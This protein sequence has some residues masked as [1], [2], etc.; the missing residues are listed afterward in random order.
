MAKQRL[1]ESHCK[2]RF[3]KR[4]KTSDKRKGGKGGSDGAD[5]K[6]LAVYRASKTFVAPVTGTGVTNWGKNP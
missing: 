2:T 1:F 4:I 6:E 5:R 3:P